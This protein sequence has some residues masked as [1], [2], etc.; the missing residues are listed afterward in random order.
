MDV[1]VGLLH[2]QIET[3]LCNGFE[4]IIIIYGFKEYI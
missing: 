4:I 3:K 1:F 2:T